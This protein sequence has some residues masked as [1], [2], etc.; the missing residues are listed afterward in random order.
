[1]SSHRNKDSKTD[2]RGTER[3]VGKKR[4]ARPILRRYG[5][6]SAIT[7]GTDTQTKS[8]GMGLKT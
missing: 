3:P 6:I 5:D 8:E 7:K 4:Y 1:M 2:N